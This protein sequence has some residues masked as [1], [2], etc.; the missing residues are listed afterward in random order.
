MLRREISEC[1]AGSRAAGGVTQGSFLSGS[2]AL[3]DISPAWSSRSPTLGETRLSPHP[4]R[5]QGA[6]SDGLSP[7]PGRPWGSPACPG[8]AGGSQGFNC[9]WVR[10]SR[11]PT[12]NGDR[13]QRCVPFQTVRLV[14]LLGPP[15]F[16]PDLSAFP[17]LLCSPAWE[18]E[19]RVPPWRT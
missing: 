17:L 4:P 11:R 10:L 14:G 3:W 2:L 13:R 1:Q 8:E 12:M 16:P 19:H 7:T 18:A 5:R 15:V 9:I 6:Q